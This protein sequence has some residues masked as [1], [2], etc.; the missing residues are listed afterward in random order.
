MHQAHGF[1]RVVLLTLL[2]SPLV[3]CL[4]SL[5]G[6]DLWLHPT[7]EGEVLDAGSG[8]PVAQALVVWIDRGLSTKTDS[9]GRFRF[10]GQQVRKHIVPFGDVGVIYTFRVSHALYTEQEIKDF[11]VKYA[12][13]ETPEI[14][15]LQPVQLQPKGLGSPPTEARKGRT[16]T[17]SSPAALPR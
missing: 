11:Y 16:P 10:D 13:A 7:Y 4:A 17:P 14:V 6:W 5:N 9:R 1:T 12:A 3:S 15:Q 2:A 8:Q